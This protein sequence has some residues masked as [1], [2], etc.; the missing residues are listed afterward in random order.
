MTDGIELEVKDR[1][2]LTIAS[3]LR[4][5]K[6]EAT[7]ADTAI[8]RLKTSLNIGN[9]A[10]LLQAANNASKLDRA[11][12]EASTTTYSMV[13][14]TSS[15]IERTRML[16]AEQARAAQAAER[17]T[18]ALGRQRNAAMGAGNA[19][20]TLYGYFGA[21]VG[22]NAFIQASDA[23]QT[24]ENKLKAVTTSAKQFQFVQAELYKM[25]IENR[26]SVTSL[27][28]AYQRF[29][30]AMDGASDS[31]ILDF[32][33]TL[34]KGLVTF[35]A[36]TGE[37]ASTI[38][39]LS[40]AFNKGKLDGD[41]FRSV[42]ENFPP[43]MNALTV[44]FGKTKEEIYAL[45]RAGL[46]T[47]DTLVQAFAGVSKQINGQFA[48][49]I[50]TISQALEVLNTKF[51]WFMG[52]NTMASRLL[53]AAIELVG[54]NLEFLIPIVVAFGAAWLTV[55]FATIIAQFGS[56]IMTVGQFV[57]AMAPALVTLG[58]WVAAIAVA[59]AAVVGLARII[60]YLTGQG[61]A[62]DNWLADSIAGIG[63]YAK[64][65]MDTFGKTA[66]DAMA[67][68]TGATEKAK[69]ALNP[70]VTTAAK[71]AKT[72]LTDMATGSTKAADVVTQNIKRI[73]KTL[74]NLI[75]KMQQGEAQA[76]K[77]YAALE[78]QGGSSGS[79]QTLSM[80][81]STNT[82]A[83]S[84]I[85]NITGKGV[86]GFAKG[87]DFVVGGRSGRDT[88]PI[89]F[90]ATKGER[91]T[92]QTRAQQRA[93]ER[94]GEGGARSQVINFNVYTNDADS[95]RRSR[96]QVASDFARVVS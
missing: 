36:T 95:F 85:Q 47:G 27:G 64:S 92:V 56:L 94:S 69:Q 75:W 15:L 84:S 51:I 18:A 77:L 38:T 32:I 93:A 59:V 66:N 5:I 81:N 24:L 73:E 96:S 76:K 21:Y 25:A 17:H 42:S 43:L 16:A 83:N 54:D 80:A 91:V 11:L 48:K 30:N 4:E 87:T 14:R 13:G 52:Q 33:D 63:N 26:V 61:E 2:A 1:I 55:Q 86:P 74:D 65:L 49:T 58:L 60:A 50:P 10:G 44:A 41:E 40:Q 45:S 90:N 12:R 31:T 78:A 71:E 62:F 46:I 6:G 19:I 29:R 53:V 72:S 23:A 7:A 3:K 82:G 35:G 28:T 67:E 57:I 68:F 37:A 79:F 34:S 70:G 88:N 89:H 20:N 8:D 39:Q 9:S 22:V